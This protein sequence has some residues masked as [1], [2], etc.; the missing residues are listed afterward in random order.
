[1]NIY[2]FLKQN[3]TKKK[4][5]TI[6]ARTKYS[7]TRYI[8]A[9]TKQDL[10]AILNNPKIPEEAREILEA[11]IET[12]EWVGQRII[13]SIMRGDFKDLEGEELIQKIK[14]K[15]EILEIEYQ[16]YLSRVTENYENYEIP[17][18]PAFT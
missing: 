17:K 9:A 8:F 14:E 18:Y 11:I 1:M 10:L 4:I 2:S 12:N 13:Q 7:W 16:K 6:S 3:K 15:E 5:K